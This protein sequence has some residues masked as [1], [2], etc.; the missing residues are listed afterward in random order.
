M[1]KNGK[2]LAFGDIHD[3]TAFVDR[4]FDA[5]RANGI[6]VTGDITFNGGNKE[7]EGVLRA[8]FGMAP[9]LYAQI[10]NMDRPEVDGL[11]SDKGCNLHARAVEICPGVVVMGVGGS[12]PTPFGTPSEFTEAQLAHFLEQGYA[13]ARRLLDECASKG[14][15]PL[16]V[17]VSH[18]PPYG[19][20]CDRLGGGGHAGS[21]A[22]RR[23]I[24]EA[25]P[26][27]C[28]CGHIHEARAEEMLGKTRVVNPGDIGSGGYV[29]MQVT[30]GEK[31]P[32]LDL[33]LKVM[34]G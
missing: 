5:E 22:V 28:V 16:L 13:Q 24:E 2:W 33:A 31:G 8:L 12:S 11:L 17:L 7:A 30:Q 23:F 9:G 10:G 14:G 29:V 6:I 32:A 21:V 15:R 3:D 34:D 1:K 18:C 4:L 26:A 20:A 25:Q 19:T 27:F